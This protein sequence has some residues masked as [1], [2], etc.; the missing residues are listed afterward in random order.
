MRLRADAANNF[1]I[2]RFIQL[3]WPSWLLGTDG[4]WDV[5]EQALAIKRDIFARP[6]ASLL[7][8]SENALWR[9][10]SSGG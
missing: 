4:S 2:C 7:S 8:R 6:R 9:I 10:G 5:I 1:I 3:L